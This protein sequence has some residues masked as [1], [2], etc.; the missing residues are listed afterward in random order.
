LVSNGASASDVTVIT[1]IQS[2][3]ESR[4]DAFGQ[5]LTTTTSVTGAS[6]TQNAAATQSEAGAEGNRGIRKM[7]FVGM[8]AGA[9]GV[10]YI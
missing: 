8:V 10:M 4:S 7:G 6:G 2:G 1:G 9:A 3:V 5:S